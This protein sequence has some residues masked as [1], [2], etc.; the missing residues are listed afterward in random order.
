[1]NPRLI[2]YPDSLIAPSVIEELMES[3]RPEG[4]VIIHGLFKA[5]PFGSVFIRIWPTTYLFDKHSSHR[6]ELVWFDKIS[7]TPH[8]TEVPEDSFF[9]F[10]LVFSSLPSSCTLFDLKEIIPDSGAFHIHDIRRNS[11]DVY[12][13]DFSG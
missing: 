2:E 9:T 6:S 8:W 4:Q 7:C 13:L 5:P 3:Y 1:M 10:T 11:D 12:F